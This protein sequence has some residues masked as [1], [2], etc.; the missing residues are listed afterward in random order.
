MS[1][2]VLL[3]LQGRVVEEK[4]RCEKLSSRIISKINMVISDAL[5][6]VERIEQRIEMNNPFAIVERGYPMVFGEKGRI[7][8][9]ERT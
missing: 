5:H 4:G 7:D 6:R 9:C 1:R 3:S 2:R 8:S